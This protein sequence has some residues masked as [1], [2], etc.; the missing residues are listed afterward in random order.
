MVTDTPVPLALT[1]NAGIRDFLLA[2]STDV[3]L[4]TV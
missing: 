3:L 1:I 4:D 2:A